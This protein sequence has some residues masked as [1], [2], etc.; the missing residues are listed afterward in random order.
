MSPCCPTALLFS[1]NLCP[2]HAAQADLYSRP[3]S[4]SLTEHKQDLPFSYMLPK[5]TPRTVCS[6]ALFWPPLHTTSTSNILHMDFL[7]S[8]ANPPQAIFKAQVM[9]ETPFSSPLKRGNQVGT[10]AAANLTQG[11]RIHPW[12][13]ACRAV[14]QDNVFPIAVSPI[15]LQCKP[16]ADAHLQ[17]IS[18]QLLNNASHMAPML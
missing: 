8:K 16:C 11:C 18:T 1:V 6:L 15:S 9:N 7:L 13:P 10:A 17:P 5:T 4:A 12:Q 14:L 3:A 2:W